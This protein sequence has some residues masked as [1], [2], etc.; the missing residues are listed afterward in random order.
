MKLEICATCGKT[1]YIKYS[2]NWSRPVFQNEILGHIKK[3]DK[4][5]YILVI[6]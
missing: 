5:N 3:K 2:Q 1:D 4:F 6:F